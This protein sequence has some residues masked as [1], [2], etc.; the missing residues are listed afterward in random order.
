[1]KKLG[2][3]LTAAVLVLVLAL[4]LCACSV[5]V[6]GE[7]TWNYTA[8]DAESSMKLFDQFFEKTR[9]EANQTITAKSGDTV[10]LEESIADGKDYTFYPGTNAKAW[11]WMDGETPY[12]AME[13][14][15]SQVFFTEK[16]Y[17]ESGSQAYRQYLEMFRGLVEDMEG[18]TWSCALDG[19]KVKDD[20]DETLKLTLSFEGASIVLEGT[21]HNGLVQTCTYKETDP[22][23]GEQP[24]RS[25][26][27]T[28]AYGSAKVD[29]PDIT[30]WY[31]GSEG[32]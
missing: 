4:A 31:N 26:E 8:E 27:Y 11:A 9:A 18:V 7:E 22:A 12:Y 19:K 20:S 16:E 28:F 10:I 14:P 13:S 2:R 29:L 1:M 24:T 25:Q 3:S 5:Q 21:S 23:Q 6:G 32:N 17:Y 30:G 15:D